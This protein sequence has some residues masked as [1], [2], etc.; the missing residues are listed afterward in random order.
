MLGC[1]STTS[2]VREDIDLSGLWVLNA[3][4]S[5]PPPDLSNNKKAEDQRIVSG[6]QEQKTD[7]TSFITR[8]FPVLVSDRLQIDQ[9]QE[10]MGITYSDGSYRDIK[11]GTHRRQIWRVDAVWTAF[12]LKIYSAREGVRGSELLMLGENGELLRIEV[13]VLTTGDKFKLKR[14]YQKR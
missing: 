6:R 1:S 13:V 5:D 7:T 12:G 4:I 3:A 10:S 2:I 11:W 9:G 14:V 8:D